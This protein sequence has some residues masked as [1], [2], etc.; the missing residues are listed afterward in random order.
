MLT[1]LYCF[2]EMS[3]F[4]LDPNSGNPVTTAVVE[5]LC[6]DFGVSIDDEEKDVYRKL[7]G[8]FH[9]SAAELM[10]MPGKQLCPIVTTRLVSKVLQPTPSERESEH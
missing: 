3:V 7:L 9:D 6:K 5:E 1:Y 8:V 4:S 2:W 10:A